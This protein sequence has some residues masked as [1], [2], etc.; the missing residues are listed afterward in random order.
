MLA[1]AG[2]AAADSPAV[3]AAAPNFKLQDQA[4]KW[5]SLADYRGKWVLVNFWGAVAFRGY[6]ELVRHWV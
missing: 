3:G 1:F 4:G 2:L 6:T 5:H